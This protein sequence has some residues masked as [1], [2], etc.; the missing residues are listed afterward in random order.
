MTIMISRQRFLL[1]LSDIPFTSRKLRLWGR[2]LQPFLSRCGSNC[3]SILLQMPASRNSSMTGRK[4]RRRNSFL[5]LLRCLMLY[6]FFK[7]EPF[8]LNDVFIRYIS[9]RRF[10]QVFQV[11]EAPYPLHLNAD[12]RFRPEG[13]GEGAQVFN[14][15]FVEVF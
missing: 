15:F 8:H 14:L 10:F 5:L 3:S 13:F 4:C 2:T 11:E 7:R 1:L 9:C 6:Q 12:Q